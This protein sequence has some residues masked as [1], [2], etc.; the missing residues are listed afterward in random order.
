MIVRLIIFWFF[1]FKL[2]FLIRIFI[3]FCLKFKVVVD[4]YCDKF[5]FIGGSEVNICVLVVEGYF[6]S[7]IVRFDFDVELDNKVSSWIK[8]IGCV[9]K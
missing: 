8:I 1:F 2:F 4:Y 9:W 5:F 6:I 3:N 7:L